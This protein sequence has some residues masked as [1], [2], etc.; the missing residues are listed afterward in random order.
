MIT[1]SISEEKLEQASKLVHQLYQTTRAMSKSINRALDSTNIYGSEW[2]ILKTIHTQGTMTQTVL[3]NYLNIEPAAISKTLRQL[4]KKHLITRQ[5]GTDK[6][7]KYIYL[8][9]LAL[10]QYDTW[11]QIIKQNSKRVFEA[12]NENEQATLMKL[13]GKIRQHINDDN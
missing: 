2:I 8:T 10:E 4:E 5:S 12:V 6:R 7:E 9:P 13:L 11:H 1:I 3:A